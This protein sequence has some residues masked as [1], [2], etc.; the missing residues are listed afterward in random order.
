MAG[1]PR[2]KKRVRTAAQRA[3][4]KKAQA[5]SARKRRRRKVKR[6]AVNAAKFVGGVAGAAA[7][8]HINDM[9]RHPSKVKRRYK[10]VKN[11]TGQRKVKKLTAAIPAPARPTTYQGGYR[12]VLL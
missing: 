5:A 2:R 7:A 8:Y 12:G 10:A 6:G 1:R 9:A 3:A 11:Y 4:L